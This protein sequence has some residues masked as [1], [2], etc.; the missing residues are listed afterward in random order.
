M[1][2]LLDCLRVA[3]RG[4]QGRPRL[5]GYEA[6]EKIEGAQGRLS[7][8]CHNDTGDR[9]NAIVQRGIDRPGELDA[10]CAVREHGKADQEKPEEGEATGRRKRDRHRGRL[11]E[12]RP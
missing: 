11:D 8:V 6:E 12:A 3:G 10:G 2:R 9:A 7:L 4:R 5:E 1:P